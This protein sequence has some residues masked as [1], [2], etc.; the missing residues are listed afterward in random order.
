MERSVSY[1]FTSP[2][3][4]I[5][6][7]VSEVHLRFV[8]RHRTVTLDSEPLTKSLCLASLK[9]PGFDCQGF[10]VAIL[11]CRFDGVR[12]TP[13]LR[14]EAWLNIAENEASNG[15]L[16]EFVGWVGVYYLI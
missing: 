14:G 10:A 3:Q 8:L 2:D 9:S 15:H 16:S 4:C 11:Y 7:C 1:S 5:D 6:Q 12:T 13:R